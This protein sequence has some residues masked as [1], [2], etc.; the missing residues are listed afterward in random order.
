M[1]RSIHTAKK[2]YYNS[3]FDKY[4]N[5]IKQTWSTINNILNKNNKKHKFPDLFNIN[6]TLTNNKKDIVNSFN[7][8]F[9]N[10]GPKLESAIIIDSNKSYNHYLKNPTTATFHFEPTNSTTVTKIIN[11]LKTRHSTGPD[12]LSTKLLQYIKEPL[13]EAITI[14]LNQSLNTGIFPEKLKIAKVIPI[15]KKEDPSLLEN[16][17]PISILPSISKIFEKIICNQINDYFNLNNLFH[18]GQYG[19]RKHHSTELA[20]ME[21]IDRTTQDM[22][23]GETP[24]GIFLDLSKAFDTL[25]HT[26][27]LNKLNHYGIKHCPLKLLESYLSNRLQYVGDDNIKSEYIPITT[28]IPQGSILSPLLFIIYLNDIS[29]SSKLFKFIV[30]ADDTT[31]FANFS[32]LNKNN[33]LNKEL[34]EISTW[35]KVNKLSLNSAKSKFMIFRKP[36]KQIKLPI[37]KINRIQIECVDNFNFLGVVIDKN[38]T[39]KNHL[40]KVSNKIVWIIGIMNKLKFTLPQNILINIY[41]SL[42]IPHINYCILLWGSENSRVSKLQ[43]RAVRIIRKESRL[44]HTD[45]IFKE[46]NLLKINDIYR[47]QLLKCY[48]KYEHNLLP[49][50]FDVFNLRLN[51]EIHAHNT[52]NQHKLRIPFVKHNFAKACVRYQLT[53]T[54]NSM[55]RSITDKVHTHSFNG[56]STYVK[57]IF[58]DTY[59]TDCNI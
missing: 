17:R 14:T 55:P 7:R 54:V 8:Y 28:G 22:D 2:Q 47:L 9:C 44:S 59:A 5:N 57:F 27:L 43:K 53:K 50:Y 36:Q 35:L 48:F 6:G 40:N 29:F 37:V 32:N 12:G 52:R 39:W 21:L 13:I 49:K 3:C 4:K 45:P 23:R 31:L 24:F 41:N 25:N 33:K 51:S 34:A 18:S 46:L 42:I 58:L 20:A 30:Y 10:I 19:F 1:K 26:I 11:E 15:H 38:L 56:F 16:Y